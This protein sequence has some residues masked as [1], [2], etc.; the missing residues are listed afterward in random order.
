[1]KLLQACLVFG[2][3][4]IGAVVWGQETG[5]AQDPGK[6]QDPA[7]STPEK[8]LTE[9][10]KVEVTPKPLEKFEAVTFADKKGKVYLD[11]HEVANF[12]NRP[13]SYDDAT[14]Y[15]TMGGVEV[16]R[17][18]LRQLYDG[19]SLIDT[20]E[21]EKYGIVYAE[22]V[23][24]VARVSD[25]AGSLP[26]VVPPKAVEVSVSRQTLRAW[27]GSRLIMKT[28]VS[29]GKPGHDSPLGSFKTGGK[30][31]MK[32]STLYNNAEMPFAVQVVGDI[33]VHGYTSVPHNPASHGCIRMPLR[34][35]NAARFFFNWVDQGV[36]VRILKDWTEAAQELIK[37]E[38]GG[39]EELAT[40][41]HVKNVRSGS[42]YG[43]RK[44]KPAP[45][46]PKPAAP[47]YGPP[48]PTTRGG[49]KTGR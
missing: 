25:E 10:P 45:A 26:V 11:L 12:F 2:V 23:D 47:V 37:L 46:K 1:M 27:Q 48:I 34:P 40:P 18:K 16:D 44:P 33:F 8:P 20:A 43:V 19:T 24:G 4:A 41:G 6:T 17:S 28:N 14:K 22:G 21:L 9:K 7:Q 13:L 36:S 15:T 49:G 29:T 30:Y 39:E 42:A 3:C 5:Q 31:A 35:E 32:L 38:P